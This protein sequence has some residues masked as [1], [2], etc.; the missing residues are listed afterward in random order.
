MIKGYSS[1]KTLATESTRGSVGAGLVGLSLLFFFLAIRE[2]SADSRTSLA[3]LGGVLLII[4]LSLLFAGR[5][6]VQANARVMSHGVVTTGT[7][8]EI[9]RLSLQLSARR[10]IQLTPDLSRSRFVIHYTYLDQQGSTRHGKSGN[11][12]YDTVLVWRVGDI[13][14][15]RYDSQK[16]ERS[17]WTGLEPQ[18]RLRQYRLSPGQ[19]EEDVGVSIGVV[20]AIEP[21]RQIEE[22]RIF[23]TCLDTS[24]N[25]F[26]GMAE[27]SADEIASLG[28]EVEHP[29]RIAFDPDNPAS[30]P[31]V[32]APKDTDS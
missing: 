2:T 15:V 9:T 6:T 3:V 19:L 32:L 18:E 28:P 5:R 7:I 8:T 12:P 23:Y 4:G 30:Y 29:L 17:V 25:P 26:K 10:T 21:G 20:T 24:G 13:A 11:L 22:R 16:P 27:L 14:E 31:G 1:L